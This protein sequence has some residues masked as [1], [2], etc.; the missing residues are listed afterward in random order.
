MITLRQLIRADIVFCILAGA[1]AFQHEEIT[2]LNNFQLSQ[3]GINSLYLCL[4]YHGKDVGLEDLYSKIRPDAENNVNLKQLSDYAKTQKLYVAFAAAPDAEDIQQSLHGKCSIILQCKTTLPDQSKFKH[5]VALTKS[6]TKIILL[7]Y[8][9][10]K[11]EVTFQ[12]LSVI[13]GNS[14]GMLI[15]SEKPIIKLRS[16]GLYMILSGILALLIIPFVG[17]KIDKKQKRGR[18]LSIL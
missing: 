12:D 1:G 2:S 16:A 8:P 17:D 6:D 9:N 7:D 15:L 11:Q 5:I 3:C 13:D 18:T 4:K 14:E 10:P